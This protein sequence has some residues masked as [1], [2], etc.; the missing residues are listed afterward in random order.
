MLS[1]LPRLNQ[2]H[3]SKAITPS[4]PCGAS[5][6]ELLLSNVRSLK[7]HHEDIE[8]LLSLES[9]TI[10][11]LC[12]TETWLTETDNEKMFS[13]K[14]FNTIFSNNRKTRGG[15]TM[16]QLGENVNLIEPLST[17]LP[18]SLAALVEVFGNKI[19]ILVV[20]VPPTYEKKLFVDELDRELELFSHY[21]IPVILT[22]DFN[23]NVL[24]ENNLTRSYLNTITA[25]GF[26]LL[27]KNETRITG[28]NGTCIDH[29]IACNIRNPSIRTLE[30]ECFSD[31]CPIILQFSLT[32]N[33]LLSST[34][35]DMSFLKKEKSL[36]DF[37]ILIKEK[38]EQSHVVNEPDINVAYDAFSECLLSSI[39]IFAPIR[40][41]KFKRTNV[42]A[43]WFCKELKNAIL[44]RNKLHKI[45]KLDVSNIENK[46]N[47]HN[48]RKNVEI[49]IR[50]LK[51]RVLL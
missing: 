26:E 18:E 15:G 14:G 49:M 48:K 27:N 19:I 22:G 13:F 17:S 24:I 9:P 33:E 50:K 31:H 7:K 5:K 3:K 39:N 1:R 12:F 36:N 23:I 21:K 44:K 38:L 29:M 25:N 45:W 11:V 41:S 34:Y 35:R 47:F 20:Y 37:I 2:A 46:N 10:N 32:E 43:P 28:K 16:I 51:K 40:N 4:K 6:F 8:A 30:N 42:K